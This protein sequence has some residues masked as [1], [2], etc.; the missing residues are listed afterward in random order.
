MTTSVD[1]D[2][3][4]LDSDFDVIPPAAVHKFLRR[5][6]QIEKEVLRSSG[7]HLHLMGKYA[8]GMSIPPQPFFM[9]TLVPSISGESHKGAIPIYHSDGATEKNADCE[10]K[11]E[12]VD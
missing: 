9:G 11:M 3:V 1:N 6:E 12:D 8:G 10:T 5:G 4:L 7:M 2:A